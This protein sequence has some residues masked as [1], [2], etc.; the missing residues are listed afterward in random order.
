MTR[1]MFATG[2]EN[3][4]PVIAGGVRVDEMEK[5]GH[6]DRWR[7]DLRLVRSMGLRHL[8][9]GPPLHKTFVGPGRYDWA[10]TDEVMAE[11]ARLGIRPI[12][13]L[14]HFGVPDWLGDFQNPDLAPYLAEY[15]TECARRYPHVR[16]W[17]PVN[18]PLVTTLFSAKYGWWNERLTSD[19]AFVRATLNVG[20]A[21]RP[22][23]GG[24]RR[25]DPRRGVRAER[26]VRVHPPLRPGLAPPRP[27]SSTSAA[28]CPLDLIYGHTPRADVRE[29]L[30]DNGMTAEEQAF[31]DG[32][33]RRLRLR[34]RRGLLRP[35][36][37]PA[38]RRTARRRRPARCWAS[39][40]SPGSTTTATACR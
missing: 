9:W 5:C 21:S 15:A 33:A 37:A 10:W 14:C 12:L 35:E 13:D 32:P 19:A 40:P 25:R 28:S 16:H 8:R 38:A 22:V 11:M 29:Y 20:R 26:V 17:T 18:E 3:S 24:H 39:T 6:Y 31:F 4:Y 30:L 1:F 34:P 36:R 23:H 27:A 2:I 7:E